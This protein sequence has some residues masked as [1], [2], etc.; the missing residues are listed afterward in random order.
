MW[1]AWH[2]LQRSSSPSVAASQISVW[3]VITSNDTLYRKQVQNYLSRDPQIIDCVLVHR[4]F[5]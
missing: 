3:F 2:V 1:I 5:K 4:V